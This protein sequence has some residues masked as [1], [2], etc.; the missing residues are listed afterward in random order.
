M[1]IPGRDIS[2]PVPP[3]SW[4]TSDSSCWVII[5]NRV[6]DVTDFIFNHPGGP[7]VIMDYAGQDAT[8]AFYLP[9][10]KHLGTLD[11]GSTRELRAAR[12]NKGKSRDELRVE[13]AVRDKPPLGQMINV[14]DIEETAK[15]MLP[16]KAMAY[17]ASAADDSITYSENARAFSRF[18]FHPRVMKAVSG[19]DPSTTMLGY[20]TSIPVYISGSALARLGHPLGEAN[21]TRGAYKS[22]ILQMV[23][24][25]S[26]LS[27]TQI[28]GA[29]GSPEQPLFFQ[30]YK[31]KNDDIAARRIRE[32]EELGYKAIFLTVDALVPSNRELDTRAPQYLEEYENQGKIIHGKR[33]YKSGD[34]S[35][36]GT[37]GG[38]IV[39]ND[40][41]MTWEKTIPWIR[42]VTK[43]PIV[44][45]GVTVLIRPTVLVR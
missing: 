2:Y 3:S 18:F 26:S 42:S 27:Y 5:R 11:E 34:V 38:L 16:Y 36:L 39:N 28:A 44:V 40:L 33:T 43:L 37:A 13:E 21:L 19:V 35:I 22:G 9:R 4:F 1:T 20:K 29:R 12:R 8:A 23:S 7:Q 32:V 41:D 15:K 30:L 17:Y 25:N 6:Y 31:H 24:S 10:E 45:K 14:R